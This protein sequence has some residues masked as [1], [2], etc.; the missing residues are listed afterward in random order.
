MGRQAVGEDCDVVPQLR[1]CVVASPQLFL[2]DIAERYLASVEF[3]ALKAH[4]TEEIR[5]RAHL[6]PHMGTLV[7]AA[8]SFASVGRYREERGCERCLN[9][10]NA[11]PSA[12]TR[13]REVMQLSACLSWAVV[14]HLLSVNPLRGVPMEPEMVVRHT[15]PTAADVDRVLLVCSPR[16]RA[17]VGMSFESGITRSE[18]CGLQ[19][20]Q[21]AWSHGL[22]ELHDRDGKG[23]ARVTVMPDRTSK[24]LRLYLDTR[25]IKSPNVFCTALGTAVEPRNFLREFQEACARAGVLAA[26][27]ERM[28]IHD[29]R[30]GFMA[31]QLALGTPDKV[32]V[33][34][35]GHKSG[36][37]LQRLSRID[38]KSLAEAK[39]RADLFDTGRRPPLRAEPAPDHD[40]QE[41]KHGAGARA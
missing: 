8:I 40:G 39:L 3:H 33:K 34:M 28:W 12:A 24:Y 9:G 16:L 41:K 37:S 22:I 29:L 20:R 27:G 14:H 10:H 7:A 25:H 35:T 19:I 11:P 38:R 23:V 36:R 1:L 18:L 5:F 30:R 2:A 32:V 26:P 15:K 4:A 31:H 6:L 13:N 21:L 17:M